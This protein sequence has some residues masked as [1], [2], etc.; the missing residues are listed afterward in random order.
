[1][2][3][4]FKLITKVK[5]ITIKTLIIILLTSGFLGCEKENSQSTRT[6]KTDRKTKTK[7]IEDDEGNVS[8][9]DEDKENLQNQIV[10]RE[11]SGEVVQVI[12]GD[13]IDLIEN[14]KQL[15]IRL[16]EIDCPESNQEFGQQAKVFT[17]KLV[18]NKK[19]KVLIK[20]KDRYGRSVGE[21]ILEDGRSLNRELIKAGLAWWYYRYS[22]DESLNQ[23]QTQAKHAKLG[24]WSSDNPI[25]PW[26]FR[27]HH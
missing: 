25:A 8:V 1:M 17:S 7:V 14:N 3:E 4:V 13:T 26:D 11:V 15:R 23:L 10:K 19:V 6:Q 20:D 21:V 12:D 24:L 9:I 2:I 16:A 22:S 5:K 27:H 18:S